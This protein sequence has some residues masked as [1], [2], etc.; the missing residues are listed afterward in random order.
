MQVYFKE[1]VQVLTS[2]AVALANGG[3]Y[4]IA[5]IVGQPIDNQVQR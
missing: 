1:N 2:Q 5:P 3:I 4:C